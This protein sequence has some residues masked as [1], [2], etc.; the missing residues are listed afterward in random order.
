MQESNYQIHLG[1]GARTVTVTVTVLSRRDTFV[2]QP[3]MPRFLKD[4]KLVRRD[5]LPLEHGCNATHFHGIG[6]L[7][8]NPFHCLVQLSDEVLMESPTY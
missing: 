4:N 1:M 2:N 5:T 7:Q 6:S 3:E 8:L